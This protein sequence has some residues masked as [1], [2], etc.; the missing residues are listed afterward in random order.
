MWDRASWEATLAWAAA[1]LC[2]IT[3][4]GLI[5]RRRYRLWYSLLPYLV[6]NLIWGVSWLLWPEVWNRTSWLGMVILEAVLLLAV[7]LEV[8]FRTLPAFP[9]ERPKARR[10]VLAFLPVTFVGVVAASSD[11]SWLVASG[12]SSVE[13]LAGRLQPR[14]M[15]GTVWLLT[16]LGAAI[17]WYRIPVE[18]F[19]KAILIGLVPY[20]LTFTGLDMLVRQGWSRDLQRIVQQFQGGAHLV[21]LASWALASWRP[22]ELPWKTDP[23]ASGGPRVMDATFKTAVLWL[24]LLVVLS[25]SWHLAQVERKEA[26]K[27]FSEF[28]SM[29]EAGE[30]ADVT[31]KGSEVMGHTASHEAF[32]TFAPVGY[33]K[34]V[35]SLLSRK[36][37]VNYGPESAVNG[38]S[39]L[40]FGVP[41]LFFGFLVL[42][43]RVSDG[44]T[45]NVIVT[46][47]SELRA[48]RQE[49]DRWIAH[50]RLRLKGETYTRLLRD[51]ARL[52]S[53]I[54]GL[55][56]GRGKIGR[57]DRLLDQLAFD[58][59]V[60]ELWG[61]DV[62]GA[63]AL[64]ELK[65]EIE[66]MAQGPA[67]GPD[68]WMRPLNT[69]NE[70]LERLVT[71]ARKDFGLEGRAD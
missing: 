37:A 62:G 15:N 17:L 64:D 43:L 69:I 1:L 45:I 47:L 33:D 39:M 19:R 26:S 38:R 3:I 51:L 20:H 23:R 27:K 25:V 60:A 18:P 32:R 31:I 35:D 67:P 71:V 55:A 57:V 7:A 14:L 34:V 46:Y 49:I 52:R 12:A 58:R 50:E 42:Y 40:I 41:I 11:A 66:R 2:L 48:Q 61:F 59:I 10:I 63:S 21:L 9:A 56:Q 53:A 8:S 70:A 29:V 6:A 54:G 30:V 13:W 4:L 24:S 22:T 28:V 65:S 16:T 68:A 36:V 5:A 44:Q